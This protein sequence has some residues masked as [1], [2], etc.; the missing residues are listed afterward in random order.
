MVEGYITRMRLQEFDDIG[1][2]ILHELPAEIKRSRPKLL[3]IHVL[4]TPADVAAFSE[5]SPPTT[6]VYNSAAV[7]IETISGSANDNLSAGAHG[8][9]INTIGINELNQMVTREEIGDPTD[10]TTFVLTTNLYKGTFHS[11][12]VS[13]GTGDKDFAGNLD[14]RSIADAVTV[15]IA[16][17]ANESNGARFIVPDGHVAMLYGGYLTRK[18]LTVDE[19]CKIRIIYIDEIDAS[20]G[21]VAADRAINWLE[22][23][24]GPV[25][26]ALKNSIVIPNGHMFKALTQIVLQHSSLVNLGELY[27][28][29]LDFLIWKK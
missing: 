7:A 9:K 19:G 17:G 3:K 14:C 29:S 16:A 23:V 27:D 21:L 1:H 2:G 26:L 5:I 10:W 24:V 6:I 28:L 4:G 13:W 15:Q 18:T 25:E 20:T 22:F 8:Q 11:F 12:G